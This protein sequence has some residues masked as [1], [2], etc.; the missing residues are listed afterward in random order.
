[1][2]EREERERERGRERGG[3][4]ERSVRFMRERGEGERGEERGRERRKKNNN[5]LSVGIWV[6]SS[7]NEP[8]K[9]LFVRNLDN[10]K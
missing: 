7:G 8:K 6:N 5:S 1:M 4:E 2:G 3:R 9:E 10:E